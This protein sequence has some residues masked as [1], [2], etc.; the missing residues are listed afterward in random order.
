MCDGTSEKEQNH[1]YL[2]R[3]SST[4]SACPRESSKNANNISAKKT[5]DLEELKGEISID[6]HKMSVDE[7]CQ[8]YET[9]LN[10]GLSTAKAEDLLKKYGLNALKPPKKTSEWLKFIKTLVSGFAILLLIGAAFSSIAFALQYS[11]NPATPLDNV[12]LAVVLVCVVVV[13]GCFQYY[14]ESKSSK[15]MDSF[16]KMIPE[17]AIV[18]R[19]G[20]KSFLQAQNLVVG[21]IV[22]L[23]NG[24]RVSA[25]VRIL[26]SDGLKVDNSSLTGESEPLLRSPDCTHK[27]PL[28]T[29]NLAFFSTFIVEGSGIGLVIRTGEH[30]AM[31]RIARYVYYS[32]DK[33]FNNLI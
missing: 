20:K 24:Q 6:E 3:A 25:D 1:S 2:Q 21:D 11:Q 13:T 14:Q 27:N 26:K 18:L 15:I 29:K 33:I 16:K 28:E 17:H 22:F 32:K 19:D 10:I 12:W 5:N 31:G 8:R 30:T 23:E 7:L 4:L 9:N